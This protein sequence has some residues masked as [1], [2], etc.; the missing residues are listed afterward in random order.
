MRE[1]KNPETEAFCKE[2]A[3]RYKAARSAV[4]DDMRTQ[5]RTELYTWAN[6]RKL[7]RWEVIAIIDRIHQ[8][9]STL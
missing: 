6:D 1:I 7:K 3:P 4:S 8:I 5:V 2:I 9:A